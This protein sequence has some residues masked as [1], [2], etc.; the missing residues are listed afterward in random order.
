MSR[1]HNP[2]HFVSDHGLMISPVW[3]SLWKNHG[4]YWKTH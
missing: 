4:R 1:I 2:T 3:K